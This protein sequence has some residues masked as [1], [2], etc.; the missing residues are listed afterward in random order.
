MNSNLLIVDDEPKVL[1]CLK[2]QLRKSSYNVFATESAEEGLEIVNSYEVGVVLSDLMMPKIDGM[3]FLE[4]VKNKNS[5]IIR[6]LLT[7]N[8]TLP[9][10]LKAINKLQVFSY[11]TKPWSQ[12]NLKKTLDRAFFSY[13]LIEENRRLM[14]LTNSQNKQLTTINQNLESRVRERTIELEEAIHEGIFM[15]ALAAEAKDDDT[16]DHLNRI[17]RLTAALC[18]KIGLSTEEAESISMASIMHD[19]G[20]I[21]IPDHILKK[22]GRLTAEEWEIMKTHTIAG[23][24]ILGLKPYY[25]VA[26]DIARS[27]HERWDGSGYPDGLQGKA[28]PLAARIT[29]V[30]DVFDALTHK[31]P[32]KPAWTRSRAIAEMA[33]Q[34]GIIFDSEILEVF[35]NSLRQP[36]LSVPEEKNNVGK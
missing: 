7:A 10:A 24:K 1:Q 16:A 11:L 23:Q 26:R 6:I 36:Y 5:D 20:K 8:G 2:R 12:A 32:Y 14:E 4:Q 19:V 17:K 31:R 25:T 15:L 28:I 30:A 9:S 21:H 18:L 3:R 35:L 13:N 22:P 34:S 33:A 29:A 27:H